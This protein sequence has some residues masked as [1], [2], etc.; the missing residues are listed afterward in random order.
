MQ[1]ITTSYIVEKYQNFIYMYKVIDDDIFYLECGV[2]MEL[3]LKRQRGEEGE[4][5]MQRQVTIRDIKINSKFQKQG[6]FTEFV[7]W[8]LVEKQIAVSLEAVQPKWLKARLYNSPRWVLQTPEDCKEWCP[9]YV[10]FPSPEDNDKEK[11]SLF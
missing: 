6:M 2:E 1:S 7:R 8:L 4:R 10:R 5:V 9:N 3:P 11:F